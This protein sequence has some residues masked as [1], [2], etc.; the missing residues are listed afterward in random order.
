MTN[1]S[2]LF[3]FCLLCLFNYFNYFSQSISFNRLMQTIVYSAFL[4]S[5]TDS[6]LSSL[7]LQFVWFLIL[8][9]RLGAPCSYYDTTAY[10]V[11]HNTNK[12]MHETKMNIKRSSR[13]MTMNNWI[14]SLHSF[15]EVHL[16][17]VRWL[18]VML[19]ISL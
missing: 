13:V 12:N 10:Y 16:Q 1:H 9:K 7:H 14:I 17:A 5:L 3:F 6:L 2:H 8:F 11:G 15:V 18:D 4:F 19:A